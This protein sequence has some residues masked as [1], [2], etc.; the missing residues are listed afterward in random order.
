[1]ASSSRGS[2]WFDISILSGRKYGGLRTH[3]VVIDIGQRY[4]K[5]GFAGEA[6]PRKVFPTNFK[7]DG[8]TVEITSG[9]QPLEKKKWVSVLEPFFRSIYYTL[10]QVNPADRPVI[11]LESRFW[12]YSFKDALATVL[13]SKKCRLQAPSLLFF[14]YGSCPHLRYREIK[15]IS[16]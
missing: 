11:I 13:F 9:M 15:W 10:L 2:S 14:F 8:K 4:T 6:Q 12:P 3:G 16:D 1:M 7:L 5:V